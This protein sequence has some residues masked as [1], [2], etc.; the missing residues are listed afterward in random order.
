MRVGVSSSP[1][2]VLPSASTWA[3]TSRPASSKTSRRTSENPLECSPDEPRPTTAMPGLTLS[4]ELPRGEVIQEKER[5]R[6]HAQHVVGVHRHAVYADGVVDPGP[7]GD[8]HL[9]PHRVGAGDQ[10]RVLEPGGF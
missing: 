9:G 6:P 5:P 1:P 10:D 2:T 4:G 7:D 3:S 8:Q